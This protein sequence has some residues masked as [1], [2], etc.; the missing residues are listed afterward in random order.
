M[1]LRTRAAK[2][3]FALYLAA[4]VLLTTFQRDLQYFPDPRIVTPAEA[5]LA[6]VETLRL[7]TDD[8]KRLSAWF[9]PP[10]EGRALI[11]YFHGNSGLLADRRERFKHFLESGFGLLAVA[12][13]GYGGSSGEPTQT[14][15][16]LDAE[17]A[18]AEAA[19]RGYSGRRLVIVGESLGTGVATLLASRREAA[20]LV[21]DSPY[22]SA[23]SV[24]AERYPIFPVSLLMRDPMRTDL[25][26]SQ[27]HIPVMMLHGEADQIIPL[28]SA[29]ALFALANEPKEFIAVAG[30]GHL[31]LNLPQ[32]YTRVAAFI[33]AASA[34]R[35]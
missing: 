31:V 5:G 3:I 7:A 21:L 2:A 10:A 4:L 29:R 25:A 1:I 12:Y 20:A 26:I 34:S 11:V 22:L 14:G 19:R 8:G 16:L 6:Q 13:R 30:A 18:Y 17:A 15:L 24:A 27:V 33:D 32:V 35:E 23:V 9:A 28:S